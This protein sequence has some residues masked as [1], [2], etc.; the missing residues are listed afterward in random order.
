M[1]TKKQIT[2]LKYL[3]FNA[4][5]GTDLTKQVL[6]LLIDQSRGPLAESVCI[7]LTEDD[8]EYSAKEIS[9]AARGLWEMQIVH[10]TTHIDQILK[11]MG[12]NL[13][14]SVHEGDFSAF[15]KGHDVETSSETAIKGQLEVQTFWLAKK[16]F[17]M[18]SRL[19]HITREMLEE[20]NLRKP[21][22]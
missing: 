8:G 16:N 6:A 13:C 22:L 18:D 12:S 17:F 10:G 4:V 9:D 15:C 21:E 1:F 20:I 11:A 5:D 14:F 2:A 19:V 7:T 3:I